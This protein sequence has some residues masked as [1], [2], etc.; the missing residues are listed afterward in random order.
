MD[1]VQ[2][3]ALL[4]IDSIW[5]CGIERS[6]FSRSRR[7]YVAGSFH[8]LLHR[9]FYQRSNPFWNGE[10]WRSLSYR[11]PGTV[12]FSDGVLWVHVLC[13]HQSNRWSDMV[14]YPSYYG[15]HNL[16]A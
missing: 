16:R 7:S 1:L 4:G 9:L 8:L 14:R 3:P 6:G 13:L 15:V 10:A 11:V 2:P 12:S 5:Y